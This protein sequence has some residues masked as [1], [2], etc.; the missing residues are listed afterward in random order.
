NGHRHAM[1]L[2][3]RPR[4]S[5][6]DEALRVRGEL[7]E[8]LV[9]PIAERPEVHP[10]P[11]PRSRMQPDVIDVPIEESL[12]HRLGGLRRAGV[13]ERVVRQAVL[14]SSHEF[15]VRQ[16]VT[17]RV[18][19][20][21]LGD[22]DE[23]V[24]SLLAHLD[25]SL[26]DGELFRELGQGAV[27][28]VLGPDEL[29]V[30]RDANHPLD[31][32]P[33]LPAERVAVERVPQEPDG[34]QREPPAREVE[35]E[36]VRA[37]NGDHV[38]RGVCTAEGAEVGDLFRR[39]GDVPMVL[40]EELELPAH[41]VDVAHARTSARDSW[42]GVMV[43]RMRPGNRSATSARCVIRITFSK[44]SPIRSSFCTK[45]SREISVSSEPRSPSSMKSV[46]IRPNVR[47]ICGIDASS[48]AIANRKAAL[49]CVFSPPLNSAT[50]CHWPSTPWT[51]MRIPWPRPSSYVSRRI[52]P[53]RLSV[54]S[55]RFFDASIS[56]SGRS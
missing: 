7:S 16:R 41:V 19:L 47:P 13:R 54:S 55:E 38:L 36:G 52:R 4:I 37:V 2:D 53:N 30:R 29:L 42:F 14:A 51:R 43:T 10:E 44:T 6:G 9:R 45:S 3:Q 22:P 32:P 50:S 25:E 40:H 18:K 20:T 46:F 12:L 11:L 56:S 48:R 49:I 1:R 31:E 8:R 24:P 33:I 5:D 34:D 28:L 26:H 15:L 21:V 27:Q 35:Q 39:Q 17:E 23:E